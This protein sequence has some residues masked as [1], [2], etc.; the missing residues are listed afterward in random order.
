LKN[1]EITKSISDTLKEFLIGKT[2]SQIGVLCDENTLEHCLP[3]VVSCLPEHWIIEI[4]SGEE[5]KNI[6]TCERVWDALTEGKFD[7]N[8][9]LINLGGGVIG[10]LGG[11]VASTY[12]RGM[13]F[14]NIPTTLLAQ[15]DASVG[16]K[17]GIDFN[18]L[19][20]HIGLFNNPEEVFIDANFLQSLSKRELRSGFAEVLKHGLIMDAGYW[21]K[22]KSF[23]FENANWLEIIKQSVQI[24]YDVVTEDPLES[25]LRKI[26]N[27]GHTIGHGIESAHL[28]SP[29]GRLLHGEAIV[30]GMICEAYLS[31]KLT[32]LSTKALEEI[33]GTILKRYDCKLID[34]QLFESII[35]L[36]YQDK[37]NEGRT[38][39]SS[40]LNEIGSCAINI[41][42]SESDILDSLFYY[43]KLVSS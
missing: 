33:N 8:S 18:G 20:N 19:K 34:K 13:H 14:V 24:K 41:P 31:T 28:D 26:L 35:Q 25:G 15:V 5:N 4:E 10:D 42:I 3:K 30:A 6:G 27:F 2:Y 7:R 21:E 11:F 12:K 17:L 29:N 43:N 39:N 37:K 16:G 32:G 23:D 1:I 38:I 9:L 40:L 36:I 22:S